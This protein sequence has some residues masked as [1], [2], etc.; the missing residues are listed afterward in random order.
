MGLYLAVKC[1]SWAFL[2]LTTATVRQLTRRRLTSIF[3]VGWKQPKLS[4]SSTEEGPFFLGRSFTIKTG[5]K[6][7]RCR[8]HLSQ[9]NSKIAMQT[10]ERISVLVLP[11]LTIVFIS[12]SISHRLWRILKH[13]TC[14]FLAAFWCIQKAPDVWITRLVSS[15][16]DFLTN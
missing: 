2:V 10:K 8:S 14:L 7:R 6:M 5:T 11:M 12:Q 3:L 15:L 16:L 13:C 9:F 1:L 4:Y